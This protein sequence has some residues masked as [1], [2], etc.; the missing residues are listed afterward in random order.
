MQGLL[1]FIGAEHPNAGSGGQGT[2]SNGTTAKVNGNSEVR[3]GLFQIAEVRSLSREWF[4]RSAQSSLLNAAVRPR[5]RRSVR[6]NHPSAAITIG[7]RR[8]TRQDRELLVGQFRA[9]TSLESPGPLRLREQR[10][11]NLTY[12][13]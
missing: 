4:P 2:H 12:L 13:T 6:G 8:T 10:Q 11:P 7:K 9:T 3:A 5:Y 1:F